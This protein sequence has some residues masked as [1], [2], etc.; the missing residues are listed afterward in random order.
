MCW[1]GVVWWTG[2]VAEGHLTLN[3]SSNGYV[4]YE[5]RILIEDSAV[6]SISS[7]ALDRNSR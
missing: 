5:Y 3:S 2:D 1:D 4:R 7:A 6:L